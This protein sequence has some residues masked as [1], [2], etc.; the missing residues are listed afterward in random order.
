MNLIFGGT[1]LYVTKA[2]FELWNQYQDTKHRKIMSEE[3]IKQTIILQNVQQSLMH[4]C[5]FKR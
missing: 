3:M 1:L 5:K 4:V 2:L